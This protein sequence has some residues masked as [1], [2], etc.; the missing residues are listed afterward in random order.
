MALEYVNKNQRVIKIIL[1]TITIDCIFSLFSSFDF[2][3]KKE[4]LFNE[5]VVSK[6]EAKSNGSI[7]VIFMWWNLK[8][9]IDGEILLSCAP[10]W[11]HP[12]GC[13]I[14]VKKNK[15]ACSFFF[16]LFFFVSFLYYFTPSKAKKATKT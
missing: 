4:L 6:I 16:F 10:Y 8:M 9:D 7:D 13:E 14:Q 5:K 12:E 1:Q 11:A 15:L 2:S 3:G